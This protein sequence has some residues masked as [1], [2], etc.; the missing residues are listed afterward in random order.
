ME[1]LQNSSSTF[2]ELRQQLGLQQIDVAG[3][4]GVSRET[5]AHWD[6]GGRPGQ[7]R[8]IPELAQL[9]RWTIEEATR[10]FWHENLGDPCPC[11]CGG[12]KV[13]PQPISSK[14]ARSIDH[15][16]AAR[17]YIE[18]PCDNYAKCGSVRI[19]G[20][21]QGHFRLC[22]RCSYDSRSLGPA[23]VVCPGC[24]PYRTLLPIDQRPHAD[25]CPR[26]E[27]KP[28]KRVKGYARDNT[29]LV[30]TFIHRLEECAKVVGAT[31]Q[32]ERRVRAWLNEA[33][34][35]F[36]SSPEDREYFETCTGFPPHRRVPKIE[37]P[38]P[39][40]FLHKACNELSKYPKVH[41]EPFDPHIFQPGHK[42]VVGKFR[43][44]SDS[45]RNGLLRSYQD[46]KDLPNTVRGWC[47]YCDKL[48]LS[49]KPV[50]YHVPCYADS[51]LRFELEEQPKM[52][53]RPKNIKNFR[54]Y[55]AYATL[56]DLGEPPSEIARSFGVTIRAVVEGIK[57]LAGELAAPEF[58]LE[59]FRERV[60]RFSA[61][62]LSL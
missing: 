28:R 19:Y 52:P 55:W 31:R 36:L 48:L 1:T 25:G 30:E 34:P 5:V 38:E 17:L 8:Y 14:T 46:P 54:K 18:L 11:G 61:L 41:I 62:A 59:Q 57:S 42:T 22:R 51:K 6:G 60:S 24:N 40:T 33:A 32:R 53:G 39:L 13:I 21:E 9:L 45:Q 37:S 58:Y 12:K 47:L 4:L 2:R 27:T 23:R 56:W 3:S 35:A 44:N 10:F 7:W 49:P 43:E 29:A 16:K 15:N 20:Q 50:K 26:E